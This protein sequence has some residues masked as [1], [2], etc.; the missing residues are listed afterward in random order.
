MKIDPRSQAI[1][2]LPSLSHTISRFYF[3]ISLKYLL[4]TAYDP[5]LVDVVR[6]AVPRPFFDAPRN[7]FDAF[8]AQSKVERCVFRTK[9]RHPATHCATEAMPPSVSTCDWQV[10]SLSDSERASIV[11]ST[12]CYERLFA[13]EAT[14]LAVKVLLRSVILRKIATVSVAT[15]SCPF[16][17]NTLVNYVTVR[18]KHNSI[19][20]CFLLLLSINK[21]CFR[22]YAAANK[23][24]LFR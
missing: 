17:V 22:Y 13:K 14:Y 16:L 11:R 3:S 24:T 20:C 9:W 23:T 18:H 15:L 1:I 4:P 7:P 2:R 12:K 8:C 21:I 19:A 10:S 5:W 6:P